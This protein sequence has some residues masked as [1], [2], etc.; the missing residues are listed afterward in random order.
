MSKEDKTLD[1]LIDFGLSENEARVYLASLSLGSTTVLKLSKHSSINRATV[2]EVVEA[3]ERKG[4]M[5]KEI[6]GFK[7]LFSPEHPSRLKN[8]LDMKR[9][10]L[11]RAIPELESKFHL[12]SAGSSIKYYEGLTAIKNL[13]NDLFNELKEFRPNDFYFAISNTAEWQKLDDNYFLENHVEKFSNKKID[14]RLLFTD[15]L[16]TRDRKKHERNFNEKVKILP[17][18]TD[19]HVDMVITPYKLVT[20][21]LHE[22]FVALVVENPTMINAQKEIFETLWKSIE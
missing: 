9:A 17:K 5:K 12:K 8:T 21:Q 18:D 6:H 13:Y 20:F 16:E 22:P 19:I 1:T 3:L 4:L 2:Y 14:R 15:S 11:E 10:A 7:T